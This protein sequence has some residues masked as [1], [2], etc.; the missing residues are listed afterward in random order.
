MSL[1]VIGY[2]QMWH[3]LDLVHSIHC[4][5][6]SGII[7]F[8]GNMLYNLRASSLICLQN[9]ST[10]SLPLYSFSGFSMFPYAN[11]VYVQN[12]ESVGLFM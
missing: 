6:V 12:P 2:K 4:L 9:S 3:S 10:Q 1:L 7:G 5:G 8:S 11:V